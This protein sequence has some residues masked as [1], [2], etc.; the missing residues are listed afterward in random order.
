[1]FGSGILDTVIG[2]IFVF[3]LVSMLV[4]IINEMI[5]A[6]LS[7]RARCLREGIV[8]LVGDVWMKKIYD[9]PLVAG[10]SRKALS[11]SN[12]GP[13]YIP[14][15]TFAN[16][17]MSIL[18]HDTT[19]IAS[20]QSTLRAAVEVAAGP[21]ATPD[22]LKAQ[23]TGIARTLLAQGGIPATVAGDLTRFL[24]AA[25]GDA[26]TVAHIYADLQ[27]FIDGIATRYVREMLEA[28]EEGDLKRTLLTLF[29]DARN[30]IDKLKENIE[31][32]F[33]NG[34]DRVNGWYKRRAQTIISVV[35][36]VVTVALNVD[37]IV[38]VRHLQT[39][40][41]AAQVLVGQAT[42]YAHDNPPGGA[43]REPFATVQDTLAGLALPIGWLDTQS[44]A[45]Q[46]DTEGRVLPSGARLAGQWWTLVQQHWLGWLLTALA[47]SLGAPFWFDMLNRVISI[48]SAG[49][50]PEEQPKPPR[51]VSVPV[52]PGQSQQ[53]ADRLR[54]VAQRTP[55]V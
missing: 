24:D 55:A 21:G 10:T 22:S 43:T 26:A 36:L 4:T 14:S 30:D 33:N 44:K 39:Y 3:L 17:L 34:M 25:G 2:V 45:G 53:D 35:A 42:Q 38:L 29:G 13:S 31:V 52:E 18:E 7:S 11:L 16:A 41:A 37:A 23:L 32:W 40:P 6:L 1:M 12:Q 46:A 15:R 27:G 47:A 51:S 19:A 20:C 5:A 49:K 50:A 48:R 28:M 9:H 54:L 8:M